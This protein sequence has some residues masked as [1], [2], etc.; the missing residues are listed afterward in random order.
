MNPQTLWSIVALLLAFSIAAMDYAAGPDITFT[1]A[2][3]LPVSLAVWRA[4]RIAGAILSA[5]CALAWV[6]VDYMTGR[7]AMDIPVHAW[8]LAS[9]FGLMLLGT[10]ALA[11]L[12]DT[13]L[14]AH[15][16]SQTD[17]LTQTLNTHAFHGVADN[18]ISRAQR[19][20][21]A[22]TVAYIDI[23]NFKEVNDTLGHNTG[24]RLLITAAKAIQGKIR[25]SDILARLGGDEFAL[26]LPEADQETARIVVDKLHDHLD[27]LATKRKWPV[28]FSMGV[29]TCATPPPS[30]DKMIEMA[31]ELM[32]TV[33]DSAKNGKCFS[34]YND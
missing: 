15:E 11:H 31:D 29:L 13:L 14:Q 3:L 2:Y 25:K 17:H 27:R 4:G 34:V 28:N 5:L 18:E 21:H 1:L 12:R 19:Y 7:L 22:F 10:F 33:K 16:L 30:V 6:A 8:N 23:D 24:D 9:R 32:Y 20:N 26:L